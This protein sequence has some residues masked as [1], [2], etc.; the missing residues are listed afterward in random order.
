MSVDRDQA[1]GSIGIWSSFNNPIPEE[2]SEERC[3]KL[4]SVR[5]GGDIPLLN[6]GY[7]QRCTPLHWEH[8]APQLTH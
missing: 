1:R 7:A 5:R 3:H 2:R 6:W 8:P 4:G